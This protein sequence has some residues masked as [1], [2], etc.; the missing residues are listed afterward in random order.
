MFFESDSENEER[1]GPIMVARSFIA[2]THDIAKV[3]EIISGLLDGPASANTT[4]SLMRNPNPQIRAEERDR[5]HRR[6]LEKIGE[7][8]MLRHAGKPCKLG[9]GKIAVLAKSFPGEYSRLYGIVV[10]DLVIDNRLVYQMWET[11]KSYTPLDTPP[12]GV[13]RVVDTKFGEIEVA[14]PKVE[15]N[16]PQA[17]PAGGRRDT[18]AR[19][20]KRSPELEGWHFQ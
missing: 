17:A 5:I 13:T 4:H 7:P 14:V 8:L 9:K 19:I 10:S 2:E 18:E 11:R 6:Y 1:G 16:W 15:I 12:N 3:F 20:F